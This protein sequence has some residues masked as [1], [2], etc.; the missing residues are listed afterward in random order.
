MNWLVVHFVSGQS[1]FSGVALITLASFLS[2]RKKG[3]ARRISTL[4]FLVGL[5]AVVLSSTPIPY[6]Y[7]GAVAAVTL[8]WLMSAF[9]ERWR[10][11]SAAAVAVAWVIAAAIE[12][13]HHITPKLVPVRSRSITIIG[14]SVTAGMGENDAETWPN[15][16]AREHNIEV[17]DISHMGE[18]A[19]SA[20]K[21][22]QAHTIGSPI[23]MLEIG[24]ND[25]LGSTSSRQFGHDLDALLAHLRAPGRQI[26]MF[27]LPLPPLCHEYGRIQRTLAKKYDVSM[28]PKRVL[29]GVLAE[30]NSTLDTIH[31]SKAG[32]QRMADRVWQLLRSALNWQGG[33]A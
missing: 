18:T 9:I 33:G 14:D 15:I 29:L 10:K 26:I 24:G 25:L 16:L 6:W 30:D 8:A 22:A 21:R 12:V 1:F 13:P 20:L 3:H 19:A 2:T 27:E 23:V 31:L 32:H 28:I 5:I 4:S 7:Y 11:W 17:Q